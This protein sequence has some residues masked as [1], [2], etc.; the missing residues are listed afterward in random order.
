MERVHLKRQLK[1]VL[2]AD[3]VG[4]SRLMSVDE[5]GTHVKLADYVKNLIEPQIAEYD[6]RL[7]RSMGDGLLVEFNSAADAV[8][9]A[10][11]VQDSIAQRDREADRDHQIRLRI[12][13]NTGDVI[14]D[15]RDIYGNSVNIA[16]RLEGLAESGETYVTRGV[17]DQL[18]GHPGLSF[19]DKGERRVKNIKNPIRVYRVKYLKEQRRR[20]PL[21]RLMNHGRWLIQNPIALRPRAALLTGFMLAITATLTIA[22]LPTWRDPSR[23]APRASILVLPFANLSDDRQQDY[24]ADAVTD[25]LTTDLSRLPG[26]FVISRAT[27]FTYKGK[28]VDV[29]QVGRECGVRYVLEGSI[30]RVGTRMQTNAQLVDTVSGADIWADRFDNEVIDLFE[31][32]EAVTGRIASSL[33][34]QLVKAE[35]RRALDERAENPDATDLRLHGMAAYMNSLTPAN[36]L[37]G[38][39]FLEQAVRLDPNYGLAWAWLADVLVSDYLN[40]WN[41]AG[42]AQLGQAEGAVRHAIAIDPDLALS[43]YAEGFIHR[44]KG[45]HQAAL[46]SFDRA[47]EINPNYARAYAQKGNELINVGRPAEAPPLA[48]RAIKLS[49]RDPSIGMFYWIIGKAH[50]FAGA[51]R[52]AI[53]WLQRSVEVRPNLWYGHLYLVG[54]HSLVGENATARKILDEFHSRFRDPRFTLAVVEA[55]ERADPNDDPFYR[56][57]RRKLHDGLLEAGLALQ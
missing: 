52:D 15:D 46:V 1:A 54:A 37:A 7:I 55:H 5:E 42:T 21:W 28:A 47:I 39:R 32:Q 43:H 10:L 44:A 9:C 13:I 20:S 22:A 35:S 33:D 16:A 26:T 27:A 38:R 56:E 53:P 40:G 4:Y 12:G 8:C 24:F 23:S 45:E 31:L 30:R 49:P 18:E 2:L 19:E 41:D 57:G 48:E 11:D 34:I 17:R 25:D 50:F 51:Y 14:T 3:V 29:R 6:G 36:T